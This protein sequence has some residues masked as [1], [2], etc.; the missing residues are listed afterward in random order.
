MVVPPT[1]ERACGSLTA[2]RLISCY[3][4]WPPPPSTRPVPLRS[5]RWGWNERWMEQLL[6]FIYI[7]G[8]Y[9]LPHFLLLSWDFLLLSTSLVRLRSSRWGWHE[10]GMEQLLFF[11]YIHGFTVTTLFHTSCSSQGLQFRINQLKTKE[12]VEWESSSPGDVLLLS[13]SLVPLRSSRWGWHERGMGRNSVPTYGMFT[14]L[15]NTLCL[16][17]RL[18]VRD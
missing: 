6:F 2:T 17:Q 3:S 9:S 13:T 18:Q 14:T 12:R 7:Q 8:H 4:T 1:A 11:I 10:R 16:S 15:F 5:S